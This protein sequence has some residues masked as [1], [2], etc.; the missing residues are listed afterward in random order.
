MDRFWEIQI[1]WSL[2][3][4]EKGEPLLTRFAYVKVNNIKV[5]ESRSKCKAE[6]TGKDGNLP[7]I[8]F[9]IGL[10]MAKQE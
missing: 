5:D 6:T 1:I 8:V 7:L 2:W 3:K 10:E 9:L 4:A